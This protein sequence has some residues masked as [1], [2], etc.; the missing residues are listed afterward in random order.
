MRLV[1][2]DSNLVVLWIDDEVTRLGPFL[3]DKWILRSLSVVT[4]RNI[5][6][7]QNKIQ[8]SGHAPELIVLDVMGQG[9]SSLVEDA[10]GTPSLLRVPW[11]VVSD[12]ARDQRLPTKPDAMAASSAIIRTLRES[13]A[14][15]VNLIQQVAAE[16]ATGQLHPARPMLRF[17][18][19]DARDALARARDRLF[20][21]KLE[22]G[23]DPRLAEVDQDLEELGMWLDR[24]RLQ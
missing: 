19:H 17:L 12:L 23:S 22:D 13:P 6:E 1:T 10:L 5:A 9:G 2:P 20:A 24:I 21:I 11:L 18:A 4:A 15:F 7:A 14:A 3:N 16:F 8:Q